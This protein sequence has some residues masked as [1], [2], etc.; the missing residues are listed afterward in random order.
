MNYSRIIY[1]DIISDISNVFIRATDIIATR[2][3]KPVQ[4]FHIGFLLTA[5]PS[6]LKLRKSIRIMHDF[7]NKVI[8]DRKQKLEMNCTRETN[9]ELNCSFE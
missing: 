9:R 8:A 2:A 7:T 5:F 1:F 3:M 4:Y 6:Y